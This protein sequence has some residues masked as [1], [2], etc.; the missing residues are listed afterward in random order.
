MYRLIRVL[1]FFLCCCMPR[2]PVF[3]AEAANGSALLLVAAE[4]MADPRFRQSVVLVTRH[5]RSRSTIGVI[6]NRAFDVPLDRLFPDLKPAAKHRLHYGGPV[7]AGQIVFMVS[8]PTAPPSA[9]ALADGLFLSSDIDSLRRLLGAP[10]PQN[11]LRVFD[12]FASWAPGQLEGEI[13]R[14]DWHLLPVDAEAI[15]SVPLEDLW[16]TLWRRATELRVRAPLPAQHFLLG[17][18]APS[19]RSVA[20]V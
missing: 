20:G 5:G 6:V 14:G 11:R 16:L 12:G 8:R 3:A 13:D 18:L 4:H 19:H 7:S 2:A 17:G 15:F 9:I 1:L 10:T